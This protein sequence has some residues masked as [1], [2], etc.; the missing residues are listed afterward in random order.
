VDNVTLVPNILAENLPKAS[1]NFFSYMILQA[2]FMSA[3]LL[4]QYYRLLF[5]LD[6]SHRG[7]MYSQTIHRISGARDKEKEEVGV[8]GQVHS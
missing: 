7:Y 3:R 5:S 8:S 1:N 4:L 2:L 6:H